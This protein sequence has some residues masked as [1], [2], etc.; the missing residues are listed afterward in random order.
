MP[1][2]RRAFQEQPQQAFRPPASVGLQGG[3]PSQEVGQ[4]RRFGKA[5]PLQRPRCGP[6]ACGA[7]GQVIVLVVPL[8]Q[9]AEVS[10]RFWLAVLQQR[11]EPVGSRRGTCMVAESRVVRRQRTEDGGQQGDAAAR[12]ADPVGQRQNLVHERGVEGCVRVAA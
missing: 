4:R 9:F 10:R 12:W 5:G 11:D 6:A 2:P 3:V 7:P 1:E 8:G